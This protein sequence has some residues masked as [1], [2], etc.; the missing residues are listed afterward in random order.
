MKSPCAAFKI[1]SRACFNEFLDSGKT[2]AH[3]ICFYVGKNR[4]CPLMLSNLQF[5]RKPIIP[6]TPQ[7]LVWRQAIGIPEITICLQTHQF[8]GRVSAFA[9]TSFHSWWLWLQGF[10]WK[11]DQCRDFFCVV[12]I[13]CV[14]D[15]LLA[16]TQLYPL[17][18][19]N[20]EVGM[21]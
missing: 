14:N 11:R 13:Y 12:R 5:C 10:S 18:A 16:S 15:S 7:G 21:I 9:W 17:P 20:V 3:Q 8:E 4:S 2:H 6:I 1:R 19:M